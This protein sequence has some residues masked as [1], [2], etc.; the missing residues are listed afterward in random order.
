MTRDKNYFIISFLTSEM[1]TIMKLAETNKAESRDR[2]ERRQLERGE[3]G[4]ARA[5]L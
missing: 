3:T 2:E 4:E 1:I 5:I